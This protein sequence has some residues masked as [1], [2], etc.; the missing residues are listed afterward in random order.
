MNNPFLKPSD[1]ILTKKA[2]KIPQNQI[3][4]ENT[5]QIIETMLKVAYGQQQGRNKPIMVGLAAPQIGISKRI[6]LVDTK[7]DGKGKVGDL[8]VYIN[9]E[10]IWQSKKQTEWYEGCYSTGRVC[11]IVSRSVSIKVKAFQSDTLGGNRNP[12]PRWYVVTGYVARI[13]QHEIDH[14]NGKAFVDHI[15][16]P[17]KLHWVSKK[18]FGLYRNQEAWRNW[19]RKCLKKKWEKIKHEV[20]HNAP[21]L[22]VDQAH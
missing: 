13:F 20:G 18:E 6:I 5:K 22:T 16:D 2:E 1:P 3:G 10:I 19:P 8:K 15:T 12:P 7:A 11:G 21:S 14:L 9:P 4:S 17:D